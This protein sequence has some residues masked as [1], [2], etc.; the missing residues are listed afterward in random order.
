[1][2]KN[3]IPLLPSEGST[4]AEQGGKVCTVQGATAPGGGKYDCILSS[5]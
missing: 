2:H 1:M 5:R 3:A 4:R